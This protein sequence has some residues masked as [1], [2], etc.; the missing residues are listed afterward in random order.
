M[1]DRITPQLRLLSCMPFGVYSY[2]SLLC[3]ALKIDLEV[4]VSFYVILLLM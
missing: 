1:A 4:T 2:P 3:Q